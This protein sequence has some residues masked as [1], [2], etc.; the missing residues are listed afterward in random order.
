ME[1]GGMTI[2]LGT[3]LTLVI[4]VGIQSFTAW[5]WLAAQFKDRDSAINALKDEIHRV[6]REVLT[7]RTETR[8]RLASVPSRD[9][10]EEL[11]D[12]KLGRMQDT[13]E[14]LVKEVARLGAR[15]RSLFRSDEE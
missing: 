15:T 14:S 5:R 7:L 9:Q 13:L 1:V 2:D 10:I 3:I 4:T 8:E 12:K 6:D 11:F